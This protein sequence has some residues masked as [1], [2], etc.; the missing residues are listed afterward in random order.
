M[1][2][3]VYIYFLTAYCINQPV[4]WYPFSF[5]TQFTI[6]KCRADPVSRRKSVKKL[7]TYD[8]NLSDKKE[9]GM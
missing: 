4:K 2:I 1:R 7:N 3:F 5:F 8:Y 6:L 9:R